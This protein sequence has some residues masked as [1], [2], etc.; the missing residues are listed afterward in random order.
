MSRVCLTGK[1]VVRRPAVGYNLCLTAK[2][3]KNNRLSSYTCGPCSKLE[4]YYTLKNI[5]M[6]TLPALRL[7][8]LGRDSVVH[9]R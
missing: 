6:K 7:A 5:G 9:C 3:L 4:V 1:R 2:A 8:L